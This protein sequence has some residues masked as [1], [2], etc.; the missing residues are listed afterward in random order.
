M[1]CGV[2]G[3]RFLFAKK[4]EIVETCYAMRQL[5]MHIYSSLL[6]VVVCVIGRRRCLRR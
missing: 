4:D 5:P 3:E 6:T 2:G 1:Y